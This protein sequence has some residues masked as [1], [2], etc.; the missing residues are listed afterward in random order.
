[1][2]VNEIRELLPFYAANSLHGEKL[3]N[4]EEALK[5]SEELRKELEFWRHAKHATLVN[6]EARAEGHASSFQIVDYA[7]GAISDTSTR[8]EIESHIQSCDSC[9]KTYDVIKSLQPKTTPLLLVQKAFRLS[10]ILPKF[11]LAYFVPALAVILIAI[12]F[13]LNRGKEAQQ[14]ITKVPNEVVPVPMEPSIQRRTIAVAF[15]YAGASRNLK[16][17]KETIPTVVVAAD[18]D[19]IL[20]EIPVQHSMITEYYEARVFS[21]GVRAS[22]LF[23]S[24]RI[25]S[26]SGELDLLTW[27]LGVSSFQH[28][29]VYVLKVKE[30]LRKEKRK[31]EPEEYE[32]RFEVKKK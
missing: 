30:F 11:R 17:T 27:R 5:D 21:P 15:T 22:S 14:Q 25:S 2:T 29:G 9:R 18:V 12:I 4:V 32:Y 16:P 26:R 24:L 23:D 10:E 31:Y 8:L 7:R 19:S 3:K 1:M 28:D 20:F 13:W 6:A